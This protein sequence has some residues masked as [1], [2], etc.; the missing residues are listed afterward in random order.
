MGRTEFTARDPATAAGELLDAVE[1]EP[2]Y[3][4]D[5]PADV[6]AAVVC[7]AYE[8]GGPTLRVATPREELVTLRGRFPHASV[9]AALIDEGRLTLRTHDGSSV[10]PMFVTSEEVRVLLAVDDTATT[11]GR[12][13]GSFVEDAPETAERA[14]KRADEFDVRTPS[15]DDVTQAIAESFG[16][17]FREDFETALRIA[18]ETGVPFDEVGVTLVLAAKHEE[19]YY[20]VSRW[21]DNA[22]LASETTF[23]RRKR[24]LEDAGLLDT[25]KQ[26]ID[27]GRP[28][29]RLVLADSAAE[30]LV[31][32]G[33]AGLVAAV[34]DLAD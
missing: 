29:Q 25:E 4:L 31:D 32:D 5:Q 18:R 17:A 26:P 20:E 12:T 33:I 30:R 7:A 27:M 11:G 9:A 2:V 15:L 6:I 28:R 14:W 34:G 10:T 23:S 3:V 1:T 16:E 22:R 21:G 19:L 13:D 8:R 24:R